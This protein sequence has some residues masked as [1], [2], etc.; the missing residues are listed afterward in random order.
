MPHRPPP[1]LLISRHL[2]IPQS[3]A[4]IAKLS[5]AKRH[6]LHH[7]LLLERN[8]VAVT[9]VG[10]SISTASPPRVSTTEDISTVETL[11]YFRRNAA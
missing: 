10:A 9:T 11:V 7:L 2:I 6:G 5:G 3:L 1:K 8:E 4:R